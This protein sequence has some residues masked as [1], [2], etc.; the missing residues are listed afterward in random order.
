M[1]EQ[2]TAPLHGL[3]ILR[4]DTAGAG[5]KGDTAGAGTAAGAGGDTMA[6]TAPIPVSV[7][8][9]GIVPLSPAERARL[10]L[11]GWAGIAG[12][13]WAPFARALHSLLHPEPET[14]AGHRA[15]IRSRAWVPP[16]LNGK[17]AAVIAWAGIVYHVL[18]GH[19]LIA[20]MK[21]VRKTAENI[22]VAAVRPLRLFGLAVFIIALI[23][24]LLHP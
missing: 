19:P 21:A 20:A 14:M 13:I 2:R 15:Y 5:T 12:R 10:T 7:P 17:P 6:G 23:H 18:I 4:G 11:A 16:E 3:R 1:S 24:I 9:A 8:D 22:E